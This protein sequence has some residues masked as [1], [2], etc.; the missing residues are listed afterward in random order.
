MN[1]E[2]IMDD[3][4]DIRGTVSEVTNQILESREAD[5]ITAGLRALPRE[6]R[7]LPY[8]SS[9]IFYKDGESQLRIGAQGRRGDEGQRVTAYVLT[10]SGTERCVPIAEAMADEIRKTLMLRCAEPIYRPLKN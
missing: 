9:G 2:M 4:I 5:F 6:S 10:I 8:A 1:C 7:L 3:R